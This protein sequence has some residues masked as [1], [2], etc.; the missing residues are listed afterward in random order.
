MFQHQTQAFLLEHYSKSLSSMG[1][2]SNGKQA[3]RQGPTTG[4]GEAEVIGRSRPCVA[5]IGM[6]FCDTLVAKD[7]HGQARLFRCCAAMPP[8][9]ATPRRISDRTLP[10]PQQRPYK[11]TQRKGERRR[12]KKKNSSDL[13]SHGGSL[14]ATPPPAAASQT[15]SNNIR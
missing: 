8:S 12:K 4:T 7:G 10:T 5:A 11:Q 9:P 2:S 6:H 13:F 15:A 1:A 14:L 3:S